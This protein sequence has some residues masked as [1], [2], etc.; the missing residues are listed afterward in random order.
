MVHSY[1]RGG[2]ER[3]RAVEV[4]ACLTLPPFRHSGR[5]S[6]AGHLMNR[7]GNKRSADLRHALRALRAAL[8]AGTREVGAHSSVI[9]PAPR[10][11]TDRYTS[12]LT[13]AYL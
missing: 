4:C 12:S 3:A 10:S 7:R 1:A 5:N 9:T 2:R 13:V 8:R 11:V 6:V